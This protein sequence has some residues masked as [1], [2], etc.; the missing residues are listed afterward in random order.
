MVL[1]LVRQPG[2]HVL[3][4]GACRPCTLAHEPDRAG[5][6]PPLDGP[7]DA[8]AA[9][10]Q[11]LGQALLVDRRAR[12]QDAQERERAW[13]VGGGVLERVSELLRRLLGHCL[14]IDRRLLDNGRGRGNGRLRLLAFQQDARLLHGLQHA[15]GDGLGQGLIRVLKGLQPAGQFGEIGLLVHLGIPPSANQACFSPG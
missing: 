12:R 11:Q 10:A 4:D 6:F 5:K 15:L 14:D 3:D 7:P 2:V 1:V 8:H 13:H 9:L